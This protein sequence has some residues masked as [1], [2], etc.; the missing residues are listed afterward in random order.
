MLANLAMSDQQPPRQCVLGSA[1]IGAL[2]FQF[3]DKAS[4]CSSGAYRA[5]ERLGIFRLVTARSIL[6]RE[7]DQLEV[8]VDD[9]KFRNDAK[10]RASGE[11]RAIPPNS[12]N[13]S[14]GRRASVYYTPIDRGKIES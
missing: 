6:S 2:V 10:I 3:P 4:L 8:Q 7:F 9:F 1:D 13:T 14:D 5:I 12:E 11:H